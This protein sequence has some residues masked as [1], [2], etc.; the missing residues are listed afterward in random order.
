MDTWETNSYRLLFVWPDDPKSPEN[1]AEKDDYLQRII[2]LHHQNDIH[3]TYKHPKIRSIQ[4]P[5]DGNFAD[6]LSK[7][8]EE[9]FIYFIEGKVNVI[10]G[11]EQR[12]RHPNLCLSIE[13]H[14]LEHLRSCLSLL[15][16][17]AV[18]GW[19][20]SMNTWLNLPRAVGEPTIN[21]LRNRCHAQPII[22][23]G[24]GP[25][26]DQDIF[27]LA[28]HQ[29]KA[30][31]VACDGAWNTLAQAGIVPDLIVAVDD[32][33]RLWRHCALPSKQQKHVPAV[34]L[35]QTAWP[36]ARYHQGPIY[37]GRTDKL[38]D[39]TIAREL[40]DFPSF[41]SG[42]CVGHAALEIAVLL[43]ASRII[44]VGFDLAFNGTRRHSQHHAVPYFDDQPPPSI[45]VPGN[46]GIR[47]CSDQS[48]LMYL[49][50]FERR[51]ACLQIPVDNTAIHGARIAGAKPI[52]LA[53]ALQALP[54]IHKTLLHQP[55]PQ[56]E[57]QTNLPAFAKK[58]RQAFGDLATQIAAILQNGQPPTQPGQTPFPTLN[59][60]QC[61]IDMLTEI[62]HPG[63]IAAFQL[64]WADWIRHGAPPNDEEAQVQKLAAKMLELLHHD[65]ELFS[66][67]PSAKQTDQDI[68]VCRALAIAD[69]KDTP[70]QWLLFRK[71]W[72]QAGWN[73][74]IWPGL[75]DDAVRIWRYIRQNSISVILTLEGAAF[76]AIWAVPFCGCADLRLDRP[77]G[78]PLREMWLPGYVP[79][80]FDTTTT[81][82]WQKILPPD[83]PLILINATNATTAVRQAVES[84]K[85]DFEAAH[86]CTT[87]W[88]TQCF[89]PEMEEM[90]V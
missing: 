80:T 67:L 1:I 4:I 14:L 7:S 8:I 21:D 83:R 35:L 40:R 38:L 28:R 82:A 88:H 12:Q 37:W 90:N 58:W 62:E 45:T 57:F 11:P 86:Q 77:I 33:E 71:Q 89:M 5:S 68:S 50:E 72:E 47:Q 10:C 31:I 20:M 2:V 13:N 3:M 55:A 65:S 46:D 69:P 66:M 61:A 34:C 24:A 81:E 41:N 23:V 44:M 51:I 56:A 9:N 52:A 29:R 19:H 49:R 42:Q 84:I 27:E 73:V 43:G 87:A 85:T 63:L 76:P 25:S 36:I 79:M 15:A 17:R 22:I 60:S 39:Q 26:L 32:S 30:I 75:P 16:L 59:S 18:R 78:T 6:L 70:P 54:E 74:Q 53:R 64:A 48:L